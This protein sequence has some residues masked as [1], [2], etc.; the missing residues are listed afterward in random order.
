MRKVIL[1]IKWQL[2]KSYISSLHQI[3]RLF[4][5]RTVIDIKPRNFERKEVS[6]FQLIF[7]LLQIQTLRNMIRST[8]G[9][10]SDPDTNHLHLALS[11]GWSVSWSVG[12]SIGC[13]KFL[14][15]FFK[16]LKIGFVNALFSVHDFLLSILVHYFL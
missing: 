7:Q 6:F 13:V 10:F 8:V 14:K 2:F 5:H 3:N 15:F 11:I 12:R 16:S 1:V 4:I 9:R